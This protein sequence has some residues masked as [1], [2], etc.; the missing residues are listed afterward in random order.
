MTC[1]LLDGHLTYRWRYLLLRPQDID[2]LAMN[3]RVSN[4]TALT[5]AIL[6]TVL[7]RP[8]S[9]ALAGVNELALVPHICRR[10]FVPFPRPELVLRRSTPWATGQVRPAATATTGYGKGL[11]LIE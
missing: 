1:S 7:D 10:Y 6:H 3:G 11:A 2:R 9:R 5:Q 8:Y 4:S